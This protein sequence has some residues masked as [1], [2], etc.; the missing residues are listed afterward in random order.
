MAPLLQITGERLQ[1]LLEG[2]LSHP[3]LEAPVAGLVWWVS[4]RQVGPLRSSAQNPENAIEYFPAAPPGATASIGPP[5]HLADH[6]LQ[7]TPLLIGHVHRC[8]PCWMQ[9]ITCL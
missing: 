7:Y 2:A 6:G 3:A 5:R 4:F 8:T 1:D 9:P